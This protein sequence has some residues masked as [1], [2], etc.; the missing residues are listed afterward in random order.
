MMLDGRVYDDILPDEQRQA[1]NNF[2]HQDGGS[3][4]WKFGWKSSHKTDNFAFWH[5][6][7]GGYQRPNNEEPYNCEPELEPF[8]IIMA[9]WRLLAS[10]LLKGHRLIR[11]YANGQTYGSDGT[12][13]TD[14]KLPGTYTCVYY[15]HQIWHPDW[16]GETIFFNHDKTD[17]AACVYPRP[18]RMVVFDGTIPHVARGVSRTCPVLRV[19]LMFKTDVP[20]AG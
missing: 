4:G 18:N 16:G 9:F 15:P 5:R 20:N 8:P 17:I 19:T 10:E 14:S 6:H 1:I 2:L 11:C 3:A 13:H 12:V 7:F